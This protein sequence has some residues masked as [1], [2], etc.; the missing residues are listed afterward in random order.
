MP[1]TEGEPF[2]RWFWVTS[3]GSGYSKFET[4]ARF[5]S[6]KPNDCVAKF[7]PL[8]GTERRATRTRV[9]LCYIVI[10]FKKKTTRIWDVSRTRDWN[11]SGVDSFWSLRC[12]SLQCLAVNTS[13]GYPPISRLFQAWW[14]LGFVFRAVPINDSGPQILAYIPSQF[15]AILK[16][17]GEFEVRD[18]LDQAMLIPEAKFFLTPWRESSH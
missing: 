9:D 15:K 6:P 5:S 4:N 8:G 16:P 11:V 13:L 17:W 12:H 7:Q 18:I 10:F 3:W 2:P 14:A 1:A